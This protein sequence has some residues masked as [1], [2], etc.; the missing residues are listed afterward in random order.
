MNLSWEKTVRFVLSL[1]AIILFSGCGGPLEANR[2]SAGGKTRVVVT[3]TFIGDVVANIAGD[4]VE[5]TRLLAVG[6]NPHSYQPSPMDM[7]AVTEADLILVN[8]FGLE[9]FL[10]DLLSGSDTKAKVIVVSEGISPL[11]MEQHPDEGNADHS[12]DDPME[13][14]MGQD[15]HVW[16][17]PN[18][19]LIWAQNITQLL[20]K[21][22][23][24]N[25]SLYQTNFDKYQQQLLILDSWIREQISKIPEDQKELV[26]DH[27]NLGYFA[28]EYGLV[29]IG[30]VIPALTTEAETSGMELA[31][32][33]DSIREYQAGAIFVGVD[34]DPSL[35]QR[36]AD[37]T[38]VQLVPLYFGSLSDGGP[39]GTYLSFMR[40]NVSA[41]VEA[42]Q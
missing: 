14:V 37:E 36:V 38:G 40:Y 11:M 27:T 19:I 9:E 16:F 15:P 13:A 21:E 6:Q 39:A 23:P 33:I 34:F 29:Q 8:G 2:S 25:E 4:N 42:L 30:A 1:A 35:A 28:H 32:L 31:E 7:V 10:E 17:D 41:I 26:T 24:A 18:N 22:D 5:I 3:T 20:A 12:D